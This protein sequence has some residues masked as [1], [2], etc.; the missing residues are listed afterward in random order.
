MLR[1]GREVHR[2]V[3]GIEHPADYGAKGR[4][5]LPNRVEGAFLSIATDPRASSRVQ[6]VV[7]E[8]QDLRLRV[9]SVICGVSLL[10]FG[11]LVESYK[12]LF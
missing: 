4:E 12:L 11:T 8:K 9:L 10:T 5:E 7:I 2:P 6:R 3:D 1:R